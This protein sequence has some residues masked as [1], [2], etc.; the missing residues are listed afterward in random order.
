M[1][2]F[3]LN[4]YWN[5]IN[6]RLSFYWKY[7]RQCSNMGIFVQILVKTY[8]RKK[9]RNLYIFIRHF[10]VCFRFLEEYLISFVRWLCRVIVYNKTAFVKVLLQFSVPRETPFNFHFHE[11]VQSSMY[12]CSN[13]YSSHIFIISGVATVSRLNYAFGISR[14]INILLVLISVMETRCNFFILIKFVINAYS[15][16]SL[17]AIVKWLIKGT[18]VLNFSSVHY[19]TFHQNV[20]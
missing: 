3:S 5:C 2:R 12:L 1:D 16:D 7:K 9:Y 13:F 15:L 10:F 6:V 18:C 4:F 17:T 20:S 19:A 11:I 8:K 14:Y